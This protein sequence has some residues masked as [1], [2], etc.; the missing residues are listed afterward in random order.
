MYYWRE[1]LPDRASALGGMELEVIFV[2]GEPET[3]EARDNAVTRYFTDLDVSDPDLVRMM[4]TLVRFT[5]EDGAFKWAHLETGE[6]KMYSY[7]LVMAGV[8]PMAV[9]PDS[10]RVG[11]ARPPEGSRAAPPPG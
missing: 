11:A 2:D 10:V 5:L 8:V 4:A 6:A 7:N 9:H 1:D 3:V